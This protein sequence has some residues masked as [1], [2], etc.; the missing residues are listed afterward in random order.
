MAGKLPVGPI[1]NPGETSL[2]AALTPEKHNY[3]YFVSDKNK[4]TYFAENYQ[5]FTNTINDLKEKNLWYEY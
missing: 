3:F 5:E 2:V 4:K 1:C